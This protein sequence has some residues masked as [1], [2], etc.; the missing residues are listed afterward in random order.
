VVIDG[1]TLVFGGSGWLGTSEPECPKFEL[2]LVD[3]TF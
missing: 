3:W 1:G 2:H